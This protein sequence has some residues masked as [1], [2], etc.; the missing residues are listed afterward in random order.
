MATHDLRR[1]GRP[2]TPL[3]DNAVAMCYKM[4]GWL[5]HFTEST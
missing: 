2:L 5:V 4:F 1:Q 3:M